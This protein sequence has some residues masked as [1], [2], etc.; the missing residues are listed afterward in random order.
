MLNNTQKLIKISRILL[1]SI[2]VLPF[3]VWSGFTFPYVTIRTVIFRVI[4]EILVVLALFLY[5]RGRIQFSNLKNQYFFWIFLGLLVIES[6][7]ALFGES[8]VASFFSD[9][10]RMWGIFTVAHIFL[11]Y[12]LLR[13]FF[14]KREWRIFFHVSLVTSIFVSIFGIIQ[15][16]P[17]FFNIYLFGSGSGIRILSTL[18]NPVY[19]AIYLLFNIAFALYLMLRTQRTKLWYFYLFVAAIDFYSL[20]LTDIRG[21]YL[22]MILG[23]AFA[24][25][26]YVFLGKNK[27]I[28]QIVGASFILGVIILTLGFQFRSSDI[29]RKTHVLR[30]IT[31]ISINDQTAKTRFI[32]WN[33]AIQGFKQDPLTGVGME[34]YNILFNEYFPAR[35][36]LLAPTETYFDRAHNQFF[37]I[38][39]ESG[40][41]ALLLYLG[42]PVFIGYY[43]I[44]GYHK[45]KFSLNEFMLFSSMSIAYFVYLFF[46]FDDF[47]SLLFFGA[48]I[49][50]IE[51]KYYN[52]TILIEQDE[53]AAPSKK[54]LPVA[55]IV[56]TIPLVIYSV[57]NYNYKILHAAKNTGT[58]I[59]IE[60]DA[61]SLDHY[62]KAV[63]ANL[64]PSENITLSYVEHLIGFTLNER[65][66][67]IKNDPNLRANVLDSFVEAKQA[68]ARELE[69]KP[70][71]AIFYFKLGQLNNSQFLLDGD[72]SS[73]QDAIVQLNRAIELSPGRIQFYLVLGE[74]YVLAREDEKAI[75]ILK[76]AVELEPKFSTT[77]YFLGRAYLTNGDLDKAYDEIVNKGFVE[78]GYYPED[79]TIAFVL[80]EELA[81]AGEYDKMVS[82]YEHIA[83]Y[84]FSDA[85]VHSALASSYVLADRPHDAISA[86]QKAAE[87]DPDGFAQEA[88]LF[89]QLIQEGRIEELKKSAF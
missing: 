79:N 15:R 56:I 35:Y 50:L 78:R 2:A 9:L 81:F 58:A 45:R 23:S 37:N 44:L 53:E 82:L 85:R 4:I 1:Y 17:D 42:I 27:R 47:H 84:E 63:R 80:A 52:T 86:A 11:F 12:V 32:G 65:I 69:K 7:A 59:L 30:R 28:K 22:G 89:I 31:S 70:N 46:V 33:A 60:D 3:V 34:N 6:I 76:K 55:A 74:T 19:V 67:D 83:R 54:V 64:I 36:Y 25:F 20:T 8:P 26:V 87:I 66:N 14:K 68:L 18:G 88:D 40:I 16:N 62:R 75:A 21:A 77:Y 51:Y 13:I 41:I 71:D 49:A 38:L 5:I 24:V 48:L 29:V 73:L 43:L 72:V 61:V 39:S 57:F 10:E